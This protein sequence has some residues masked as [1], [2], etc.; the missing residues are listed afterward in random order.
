MDIIIITNN[1]K[2]FEKFND[3]YLVEYEDSTYKEILIKVRNKV[4]EGHEV[5]THPLASSVKPNE[6]PFKSIIIS[7]KQGKLNYNSLT[8]IEN[9]I[10]TY[11]KFPML[12]VKWTES[13]LDDFRTIDLT[14]IESALN[15]N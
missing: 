5:L 10:G 3:K 9:S 2:V 14:M 4:H 8:V 15:K 7:K 11:D 1:K 13:V 6:T 12:Q